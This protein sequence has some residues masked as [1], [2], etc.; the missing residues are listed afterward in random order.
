[1][2]LRTL[3]LVLFAGFGV[4]LLWAGAAHILLPSP[5]AFVLAALPLTV[6]GTGLWGVCFRAPAA[7][8]SDTGLRL[9]HGFRMVEIA[10]QDV[11]LER[12]D[13]DRL[14]IRT[15]LGRK[16][17]QPSLY[18]DPSAVRTFILHRLGPR[19]SPALTP[20]ELAVR[21]RALVM[22]AVGGALGTLIGGLILLRS[23]G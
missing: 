13:V 18:A 10:W 19:A 1:M 9:R 12:E 17:L 14:I 2:A 6:F 11:E 21:R 23:C 15:P 4:G 8:V 16:V 3:A 7:V 20:A 22:S 5:A